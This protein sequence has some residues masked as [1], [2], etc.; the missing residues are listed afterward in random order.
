MLRVKIQN[1][2][3]DGLLF[4]FITF[5]CVESRY[6]RILRFCLVSNS[7]K[8]KKQEQRIFLL[9]GETAHTSSCYIRNKSSALISYNLIHIIWLRIHITVLTV[10]MR[11][12]VRSFVVRVHTKHIL[13]VV[14]IVS[15]K[16]INVIVIYVFPIFLL[17]AS[18]HLK[19]T[20]TTGTGTRH[21][22]I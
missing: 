2:T 17:W 13:M 4:R 16:F 7:S 3:N 12:W 11:V 22:S 15:H 5:L 20:A 6:I 8:W 9:P 18:R 1:G 10:Y 19:S 14:R 21:G